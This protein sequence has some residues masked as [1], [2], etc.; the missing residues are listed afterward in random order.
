MESSRIYPAS[1]S[2][3][4]GNQSSKNGIPIRGDLQ[5]VPL[6]L[7]SKWLARGVPAIPLLLQDTCPAL[8]PVEFPLW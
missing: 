7:G 8:G 2:S 1:L 3:T 5:H 4:P 6:I